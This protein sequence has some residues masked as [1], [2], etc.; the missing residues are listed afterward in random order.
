MWEPT[1]LS[2]N[3]QES[4]QVQF[5]ELDNEYEVGE[6]NYGSGNA[7]NLGLELEI[8][9]GQ[10]KLNCRESTYGRGPQIN[11]DIRE[12]TLLFAAKYLRNEF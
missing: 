3:S 11:L 9:N 7:T 6:S 4:K 8:G 2:H 1:N 10:I 12:F 5:F